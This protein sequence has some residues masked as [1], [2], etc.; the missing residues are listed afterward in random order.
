MRFNGEPTIDQ[1]GPRR[2]FFRLFLSEMCQ[3]SGMFRGWPDH[4]SPIFKKFYVCGKVMASMIVQGGQAPNCFSKPIVHFIVSDTINY[5]GNLDIP[6][7]D[8]QEKLIKVSTFNINIEACVLAP[9]C[10]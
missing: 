7:K 8:I 6:D 1:G 3:R 10:N 9:L 4:L 5:S 2:E